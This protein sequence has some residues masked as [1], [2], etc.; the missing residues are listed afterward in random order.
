MP[1]DFLLYDLSS[2]IRNELAPYG[3][4]LCM[5]GAAPAEQRIGAPEILLAVS[6]ILFWAISK[7]ASS[8][9][10]T[11][12]SEKAKHAPTATADNEKQIIQRLES[13]EKRLL[14]ANEPHRA[15]FAILQSELLQLF[16][17]SDKQ[18]DISFRIEV[19]PLKDLLMQLG[20]SS[21][22]ASKL[23]I[24][25]APRLEASIREALT[26]NH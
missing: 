26:R 25:L 23:A 12:G 18:Q 5:R 11:L 2:Q 1:T 13:I 16:P 22:A 10:S 7:Y 24:T 14:V 19:Q 20:L 9:L 21:R 17:P 15:T 6:S 8:Y 3:Q 4:Y